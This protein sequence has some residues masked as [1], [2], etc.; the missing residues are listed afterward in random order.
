MNQFLAR[1]I[2]STYRYQ[3]RTSAGTAAKEIAGQLVVSVGDRQHLDRRLAE[4]GGLLSEFLTATAQARKPRVLRPHIEICGLIIRACPK[5]GSPRAHCLLSSQEAFSGIRGPIG[6]RVPGDGP[7]FR[8]V[9]ADLLHGGDT[10]ADIGSPGRLAAQS[11]KQL[12]VESPHSR[13]R[14]VDPLLLAWVELFSERL[15]SL[16]DNSKLHGN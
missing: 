15:G 9:F 4:P 12:E 8:I 5:E 16:I 1:R 13:I 14:Q 3:H 10:F 7:T 6:Q 11:S 2:E